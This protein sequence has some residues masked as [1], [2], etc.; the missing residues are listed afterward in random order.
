MVYN[1]YTPLLCQFMALP[2]SESQRHFESVDHSD[3]FMPHKPNVFNIESNT[4]RLSNSN[5]NFKNMS[6]VSACS[7]VQSEKRIQ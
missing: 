5:N 3:L 2:Q 7:V 6:L 4:D 1:R